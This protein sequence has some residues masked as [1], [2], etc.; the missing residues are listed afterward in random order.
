MNNTYNSIYVDGKNI[1]GVSS[2][3]FTDEQNWFSNEF[4]GD[5]YNQTWCDKGIVRKR[6]LTKQEYGQCSGLSM[7]IV[8]C[9]MENI[10]IPQDIIDLNKS[11]NDKWFPRY[12]TPA[13]ENKINPHSI[14]K[15]KKEKQESFQHESEIV[16]KYCKNQDGTFKSI[17]DSLEELSKQWKRLS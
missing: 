11:L 9:R 1:L 8:L 10:L 2:F 12:E 14:K 15:T 3:D 6:Y 5:G 13:I 7:K 4:T 16:N 17:Y